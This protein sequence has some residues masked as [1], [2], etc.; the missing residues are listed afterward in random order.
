MAL[1]LISMDVGASTKMILIPEGEFRPLFSERRAVKEKIQGS[2]KEKVEYKL[3][4]GKP[5]PVA[6][7]MMDET[8]VTRREF[9]AFVLQNPQWQRS[10]VKTLF[11]EDTYLSDWTSDSEIGVEQNPESPIRFVSWFAARAYCESQGKRLPTLAEWERAAMAFKDFKKFKAKILEWYGEPTPAKIPPVGSGFANVYGVKDLHGLVWEW[12]EDFNSNL[13]TGESR[14]DGSLERAA[15]CG[16]GAIGAADFED[17]AAFMR[18]GFRSSL[19]GGFSVA[20][21]GFRCVRAPEK[22]EK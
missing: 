8:P 6:A 4:R 18:F 16:A 9:Q 13:V 1:A 7:F 11:A 20:N 3:V 15:Y 5:I 21:L 12:I 2:D 19:R 17:Y 10:K 22:G 14:G